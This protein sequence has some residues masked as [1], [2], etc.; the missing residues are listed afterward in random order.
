MAAAYKI[1][2]EIETLLEPR[3][4]AAEN[5][6]EFGR[7]LEEKF[8]DMPNRIHGIHCDLDELEYHGP[9]TLTEWSITEDCSI[10]EDN[11]QQFAIE[12]TSPIMFFSNPA[13]KSSVVSIFDCLRIN[14]FLQVNHSCGFHVHISKKEASWTREDLVRISRAIIYFE[15]SLELIVPAHRRGSIWAKNNRCDNHRFEGKSDRQ[16]M[17][18]I[19][20]C[21]DNEELAQL[22][23]GGNDRNFSWNFTNLLG[24]DQNTIEFRRGPG[25]TNENDAF[26]W[27]EFVVRF[28]NSA[29]NTG[30]R[31]GLSAFRRD[32]IGLQ[33][34]LRAH[35][36]PN[37][38]AG[39]LNPLFDGKEGYLEPRKI[40]E[41]TAS[42]RARVADKAEEAY[43][44]KHMWIA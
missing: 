34:F 30:S 31:Y 21:K 33:E 19:D 12:F 6:V 22:M 32:A 38:Q 41:L 4:I 28:V 18:L 5:L 16:A 39:L 24:G 25:I 7:G 36:I 14:T 1:G 23:N 3:R 29:R 2:I 20:G 40:G 27:V 42:Q 13:W 11:S 35:V 15:P 10:D 26:R 9:N 44:K 37:S 8:L 43:R 17:D